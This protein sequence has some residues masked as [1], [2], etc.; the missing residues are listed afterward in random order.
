MRSKESFL[1][2]VYDQVSCSF[3]DELTVGLTSPS[4]GSVLVGTAVAVAA[5]AADADGT[6][7]S[8]DFR[9]NGVSIGVDNTAPYTATF[10]AAAG[11]QTVTAIATDN[12]GASTFLELALPASISQRSI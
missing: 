1:V 6:V 8:V 7:T 11:V 10:N 3:K 2:T 12:G 4:A 9:V 5:T